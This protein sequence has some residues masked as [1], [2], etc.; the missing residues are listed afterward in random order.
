MKE[1]LTLWFIL[2]TFGKVGIVFASAIL[3]TM[4]LEKFHTY[5]KKPKAK[6]SMSDDISEGESLR[7]EL[8]SRG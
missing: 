4:G 2:T 6:E 5:K 8:R 1:G 3:L 7:K